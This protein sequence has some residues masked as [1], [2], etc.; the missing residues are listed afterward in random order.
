MARGRGKV[1][2]SLFPFLSVLC[3][4]IGVFMLFLV[5]ILCARVIEA[6]D[7]G[8]AKRQKMIRKIQQDRDDAT[9]T[10]EAGDRDSIDAETYLALDQRLSELTGQLASRHA[11]RD[12]LAQRLDALQATL[13]AKRDELAL[14]QLVPNQHPIALDKP[15]PVRPVPDARF[16]VAKKPVFVEVKAEGYLVQPE[17]KLYPPLTKKTVGKTDHYTASREFKQFLE[18]IDKDRQQRYLLIL[19]HPNGI[20]GYLALRSYLEQDFNEKVQFQ[21]GLITYELTKSRI[22]LGVE[23]F[24]Q[25]WQFI[26]EQ[27]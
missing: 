18:G 20:E 25:D 3:C 23:P 2:V 16:R 13:D 19:T 9:G 22:D 7:E 21:R 12:E 24:S 15:D 10:S 26:A 1:E 5:V 8:Q 17:K 6:D 27:H 4:M 11:A 14:G